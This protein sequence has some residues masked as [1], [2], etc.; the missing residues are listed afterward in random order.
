MMNASKK[1]VTSDRIILMNFWRGKI[2]KKV[3]DQLA[4]EQ[5]EIF[6]K[7]R[8]KKEAE[9]EAQDDDEELR[10]YLQNNK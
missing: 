6:H 7:H 2:A 5:Y 3:A 4:E 8:L 1:G 9:Q 10:K